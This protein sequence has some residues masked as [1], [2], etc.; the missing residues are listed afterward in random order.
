LGE[1]REEGAAAAEDNNNPRRGQ[2]SEGMGEEMAN[3]S[4][5][6]AANWPMEEEEEGTTLAGEEEANNMGE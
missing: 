4:D 5:W 2:M 1:L 6:E 3:S